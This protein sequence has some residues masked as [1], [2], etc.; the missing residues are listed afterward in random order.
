[1]YFKTLAIE[2]DIL[3][4]T[5]SS[6]LYTS[7]TDFQPRTR[8]LS[9]APGPLDTQMQDQI[10]RSMP[11]CPTREIFENMHA[12]GKLVKVETS[13]GVL[14]RVLEQDVFENGSHVDFYDVEGL[15]EE[16]QVGH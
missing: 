3:Q 11:P 16:K 12:E 8:V 13:A 4:K 10:R 1:M 15:S 6:T 5:E 14:M 2:E 9:Y 7:S